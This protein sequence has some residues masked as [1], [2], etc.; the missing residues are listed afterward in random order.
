MTSQ[1]KNA[2][3][4]IS[5]GLM[6]VLAACNGTGENGLPGDAEDDQ[7]FSG[8]GEEEIIHLSGAEPFWSGEIASGLL[9]YSTP[10]DSDGQR[11][12]IERFA[13]RGGLSFSAEVDGEALDLMITPAPC[14]DGMSERNYPFTVTM[15]WGEIQR[16]GCGWT[17]VQPYEG[18]E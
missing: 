18:G 7:P 11:I 16:N 6:L 4:A 3:L 5:T 15:E 8:I 9:T 13:G 1:A 14:S 2:R 17:N 12:A 10:A